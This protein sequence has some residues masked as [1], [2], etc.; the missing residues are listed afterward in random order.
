MKAFT[1]SRKATGSLRDLADEALVRKDWAKAAKL[2]NQLL[3]IE[4]E[5][6]APSTI[7]AKLL[8][9]IAKDARSKMPRLPFGKGLRSILQMRRSCE[10]LRKSPW[11]GRAGLRL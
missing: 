2:L 1:N 11:L 7:F 5:T 9:P 6:K 3:E 8:R 4:G 10:R